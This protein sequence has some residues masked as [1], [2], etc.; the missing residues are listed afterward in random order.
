L[1]EPVPESLDGTRF[2]VALARQF[3]DYSRA[4]LQ[5]WIQDGRATVE[6]DRRRAR[7]PVFRGEIMEVRLPAVTGLDEDGPA[8][9]G[10]WPPEDIAI[11]IVYQ[12]DWLLV[13]D[14]PPGLVVH[15]G[16]GVPGGTLVNAL[17]YRDPDLGL[18]PRAGLVHRLDKDTSGLL[19]VARR[20]ESLTALSRL[21]AHR[22]VTRRYLAIVK[23]RLVAGGR[24]DAPIGRHPAAR[25][26]MAVVPTGRH[27]RTD[28]RVVERFRT[29]SLVRLELHTG[30]THQI[31]VH[32]AHIGHPVLGDPVYGGR[33]RA[34]RGAAAEVNQTLATFRRQAL[35]AESLAF[36]HPVTGIPM[37][38]N[39]PAPADFLSV[40][41]TI[42]K[43][44]NEGG[45]NR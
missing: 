13:V 8:N 17:V 6:G 31:R 38:W 9:R 16:A 22:Q 3:P 18:L 36:D 32:M 4:R 44:S 43:D 2:D 11:E 5:R 29:H 30:R 1:H 7:D 10:R 28:Y 39:R 24:V 33:T 45:P 26:R 37:R 34:L 27:A 40:L 20:L 21:L 41:E 19:V 42:R 14:K 12:D 35:H 23:G 25:T 15:P